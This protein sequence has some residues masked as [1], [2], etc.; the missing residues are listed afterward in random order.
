MPVFPSDEWVDE[1]CERLRAH[2]GA[3]RMAAALD[4]VYRLTIEPAGALAERRS[5][6]VVIEPGDGGATVTPSEAPADRPRLEIAAGYD[7]WVQL[8]RGEL[9][10]R[11]A[12]L[13]RRIRISG[14]LGSVTS[15]LSDARPLL[16]ALR[17]VD[18]TFLPVEP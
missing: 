9:D 13:L 18:S 17:A 15:S 1:F 5:Y 7:R 14:D 4:G 12:Y 11:M 6:D 10:V 8:L 16:D 2:P 3:E